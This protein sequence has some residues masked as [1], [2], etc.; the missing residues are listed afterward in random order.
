[1]KSSVERVREALKQWDDGHIC[2]GE[3][4]SRVSGNVEFVEALE[5]GD[6]LITF[7]SCCCSTHPPDRTFKVQ[8]TMQPHGFEAKR[9]D[10]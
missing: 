5:A 8:I 9:I 10:D 6:T 1:M 2:L 3:F 4:E 7:G